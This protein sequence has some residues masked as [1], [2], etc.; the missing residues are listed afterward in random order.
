MRCSA[1]I[2][3]ISTT[4][5]PL[6]LTVRPA[7]RLLPCIRKKSLPLAASCEKAPAVRRASE[8]RALEDQF[9]LV[10]LSSEV[11][12]TT[13]T[14]GSALTRS[15]PRS[16]SA[17]RLS[18]RSCS[19]R[20]SARG[21]RGAVPSG[22]RTSGSFALRGAGAGAGGVDRETRNGGPRRGERALEREAGVRRPCDRRERRDIVSLGSARPFEI[23]SDRGRPW[24]RSAP[25][26]RPVSWPSTCP[27]E[28][29]GGFEFDRVDFPVA[30][31]ELAEFARA[32]GETAP[33]FTDP[34]HPEF[35][36]VP[37]FPTKY[38]GRRMWPDDF[39]RL[40]KRSVGFDGGKA[41]D[42]RGAIRAGDVLTARS[43]IHDIFRRRAAPA[44]WSSSST[45]GVQQRI[46]RGVAI[47][48]WRVL[49]NPAPTDALAD[50]VRRRSPGLR[51]RLVGGDRELFPA[52]SGILPALWDASRAKGPP[53]RDRPRHH[54]RH[55]R[56]LVH[57]VPRTQRSHL[58]T[59]SAPLSWAEDA[60]GRRH[61]PDPTRASSRVDRTLAN[62]GA[63]PR[64]STARSS[65]AWT[66]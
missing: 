27:A 29:A 58:D 55:P 39:P 23:R 20:R 42:V 1:G 63:N 11:E 51:D 16:T 17:D 64:V 28:R 30:A 32:V 62:E 52:A 36:A 65:S 25:G 33:W 6:R 15:P 3:S 40:S 26:V 50:A 18:S 10:I 66:C 7:S 19:R 21:R 12:P 5:D 56:A 35:R 8:Y 13:D 53:L 45:A 38:H 43:H 4:L 49:V 46:G 24:R 59:R 57:R 31:E 60:Q 22:R 34:A 41:V 2:I 37:N 47:V 54:E 9:G 44:R 48:D 14:V 61:E